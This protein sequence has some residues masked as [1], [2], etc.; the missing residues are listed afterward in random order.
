MLLRRQKIE[1]KEG[2]RMGDAGI[3]RRSMMKVKDPA[4]LKKKIN[5]DE[6][7]VNRKTGT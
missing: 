5:P 7:C 6:L 1:T 3:K 4:R 2:E